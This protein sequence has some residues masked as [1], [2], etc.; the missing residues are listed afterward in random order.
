MLMAVI[1]V[2]YSSRGDLKSKRRDI[3]ESIVSWL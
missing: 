3:S 2:G 1:S